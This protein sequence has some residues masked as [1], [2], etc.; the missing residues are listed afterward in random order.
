[1]ARKSDQDEVLE[2]GNIYFLYRP[3]VEKEHARGEKDVERFYIVL[4]PEGKKRYREIIIGRKGLPRIKDGGERNWGF[5]KLVTGD[6]HQM[7]KEFGPVEYETKTRG[8]REVSAARPA[9]EGVYAIVRHGRHTHL[10][11][12]L[13]LPE[14]PKEVQREFRIEDEGS[15]VIS[16][17]NPEKPSP[18]RAGLGEEQKAEFPDKLMKVFRDRRFADADPPE[19]L[20]YEGAEI[21]LVGAREDPG[22]E[23]G[24]RLET[25]R[26]TASSADIFTDLR[27]NKKEHPVKPLFEGKWE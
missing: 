16:V 20:D 26:E 13:E 22:K 11:Y 4:S 27:L 19:F 21:M 25:G 24:V 17:K 18:G 15:Y 2:R 3:K 8:E 7:E 14:K 23:L 1:M 12:S 6:P 10:A 5:V 9:G